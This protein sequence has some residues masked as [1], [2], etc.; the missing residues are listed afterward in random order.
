M[1]ATNYYLPK[2]MF[3]VQVSDGS[4]DGQKLFPLALIASMFS[5]SI[6]DKLMSHSSVLK[7]CTPLLININRNIINL[8]VVEKNFFFY[9]PHLEFSCKLKRKLTTQSRMSQLFF[10]YSYLPSN[11]TRLLKIE[12]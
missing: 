4:G 2:V 10:R 8:D 6:S 11:D 9:F 1:C 5:K 12:Q 3:A 7:D